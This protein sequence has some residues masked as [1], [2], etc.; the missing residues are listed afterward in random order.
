MTGK[1]ITQEELRDVY[2]HVLDVHR[3]FREYSESV[4]K[5][6]GHIRSIQST[7]EAMRLAD[8]FSR[9]GIGNDLIVVSYRNYEEDTVE[10]WFGE[11][12]SADKI[13]VGF[14]VRGCEGLA[15]ENIGELADNVYQSS[16]NS[17]R[18]LYYY[19]P[20]VSHFKD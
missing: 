4:S 16:E 10:T 20:F 11:F 12:A 5:T 2:N 6:L 18:H 1:R 8:T 14:Y 19:D 7:M 17:F 13:K 3:A 15:F 9:A